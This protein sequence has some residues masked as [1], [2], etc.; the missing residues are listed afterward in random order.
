MSRNE[1]QAAWPAL[2]ALG[3]WRTLQC[4]GEQGAEIASKCFLDREAGPN[5]E[6]PFAPLAW[7]LEDFKARKANAAT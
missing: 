1:W 7:R 6:F 2:R 3:Y 5:A 4:Y